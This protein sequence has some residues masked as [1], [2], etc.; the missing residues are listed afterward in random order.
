MIGNNSSH[1]V[2]RKAQNKKTQRQKRTDKETKDNTIETGQWGQDHALHTL[3]INGDIYRQR[4]L[5]E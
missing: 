1:S 5:P 2:L 4:M 3:Q